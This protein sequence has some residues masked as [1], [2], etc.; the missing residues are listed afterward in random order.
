MFAA[1]LGFRTLGPFLRFV[2]EFIR[3]AEALRFRHLWRDFELVVVTA[4]SKSP[5]KSTFL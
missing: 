4:F 2:F 5:K 1:S 3:N